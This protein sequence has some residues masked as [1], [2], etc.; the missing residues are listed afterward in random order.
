[1]LSK[2]QVAVVKGNSLGIGFEVYISLAN[3]GFYTY[4][5][6]RNLRIQEK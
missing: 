5:T 2:K 3:N 1:M 6:V 4:A